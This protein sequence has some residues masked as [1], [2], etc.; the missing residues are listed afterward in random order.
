MNKEEVVIV[1]K[2]ETD[3]EHVNAIR[4]NF[5]HLKKIDGENSPLM[6]YSGENVASVMVYMKNIGGTPLYNISTIDCDDVNVL[7]IIQ[8][9]GAEH[10]IPYA[11]LD[12][13]TKPIMKKGV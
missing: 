12:E 11:K 8:K 1:L 7:S 4:K 13:L 3:D 2:T 5:E 10:H 9:D 6:V